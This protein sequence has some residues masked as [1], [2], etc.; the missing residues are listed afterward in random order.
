MDEK[1]K[2]DGDQASAEVTLTGIGADGNRI[3][4]RETCQL[5]KESG[6]WFL[7]SNQY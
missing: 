1:I 7:L 2:V 3:K 4:Q 6:R 5:V